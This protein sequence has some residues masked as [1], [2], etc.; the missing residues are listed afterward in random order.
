LIKEIQKKFFD[1]TC[2]SRKKLI[3]SLNVYRS[4]SLTNKKFNSFS[5]I[6]LRL[7]YYFLGKVDR[8]KIPLVVLLKEKLLLKINE[9]LGGKTQKHT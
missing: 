9:S 2:G 4:V 3:T 6:F 5:H 7:Y 1:E 8:I